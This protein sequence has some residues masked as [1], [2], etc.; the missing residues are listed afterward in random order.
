MSGPAR[1]HKIGLLCMSL[2]LACT[3]ATPSAAADE[4]DADTPHSWYF[5]A[6][7]YMHFSDDEDYVGDRWFLGIER[8]LKRNTVIGL[9]VF[10][11]SF[12]QFSQYLY[13][14]K[15]WYPWQRFPGFRLKLTGGIAHGYKG[16]RQD[17]SPINWGD[18]WA[19]AAIPAVGYQQD[20]LGIDVALLSDS[21]LLFLLGYEF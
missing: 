19:I 1:L 12:G 16:E 9:S 10:D 7:G 13:L 8:Q 17:T 21:G 14:G 18:G 11:N 15:S 20:R 4:A 6:G 2:A 5:Q 3:V